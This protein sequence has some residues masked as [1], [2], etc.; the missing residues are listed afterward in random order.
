LVSVFKRTLVDELLILW[1]ETHGSYT[2]LSPVLS[3]ELSTVFQDDF[4]SRTLKF[5]TSVAR[6]VSFKEDSTLTTINKTTKS[7]MTELKL[8]EIDRENYTLIVDSIDDFWDGSELALTYL[9][10]LMH[11]CLELSTQVPGARALLLLREN[12]FER[13]RA[14]DSESSR[15]ETSVTGLDSM[16]LSLS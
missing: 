15:V 14:R 10:A 9:T 2:E 13:V 11:A 16:P 4:D 1:L 5:I 7:L 3:D 6:A 12:I 8:L